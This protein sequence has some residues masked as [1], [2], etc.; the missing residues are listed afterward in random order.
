MFSK[1]H[2]SEE[3]LIVALTLHHHLSTCYSPPIFSPLISFT[4]GERQTNHTA[5]DAFDMS[6]EEYTIFCKFKYSVGCRFVVIQA[7][8][9][10]LWRP[11]IS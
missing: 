11:F 10:F 5:N 4:D 2:I 9:D 8:K 6:L 3:T 1:F 7:G